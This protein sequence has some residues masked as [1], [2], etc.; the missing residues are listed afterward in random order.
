MQDLNTLS[1][2]FSLADYDNVVLQSG[3]L[4]KKERVGGKRMS[5]KFEIHIT[6]TCPY[7]RTSV[8]RTSS[9]PWKFV[10]DMG[11]SSH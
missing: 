5:V 1:R 4:R 8:A 9:G 2:V 10:R 3:H 7:S 6:K 11:S